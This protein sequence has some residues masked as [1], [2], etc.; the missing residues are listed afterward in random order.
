MQRL[1]P[2]APLS[3]LKEDEQA[4]VIAAQ[5]MRD[6]P[7]PEPPSH[8]FPTIERWALAFDRYRE[9]FDGKDGPLPKNVLEKAEGLF[10]DF[11]TPSPERRLL[12]GDLH[13]ENI[14]SNGEEC[15]LAIDPKGVIADPA[16]EAARFQHNP[17][18]QFLSRENPRA[19]AQRRSE[20]LASIL[21]VERAR[22]LAWGFFDAVLAALW[23][24]EE[25]ADNWHYL[26]SCAEILDTLTD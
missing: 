10:R 7:I 21:E 4:T 22:L 13:H 15:W 18:P 14:L 8:Q 1:V 20:I 23:C 2:G 3:V 19:V 25:N 5:L 16:Y 17:I 11:Q 9:R 24:I 6:L 12:H 26:L